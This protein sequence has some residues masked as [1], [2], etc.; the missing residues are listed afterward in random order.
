MIAIWITIGL[1]AALGV[2]TVYACIVAGSDADDES[3][4][5]KE[6]RQRRMSDGRGHHRA[7]SRWN[8]DRISSRVWTASNCV[9]KSANR[10]A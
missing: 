8:Y 10:F 5:W 2:A 4:Q 3:E 9:H 6:S 7:Y 1:V